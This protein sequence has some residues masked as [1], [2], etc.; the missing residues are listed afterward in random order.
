MENRIVVPMPLCIMLIGL[1][2]L[3][4][5]IA[6]IGDQLHSLESDSACPAK[7]DSVIRTNCNVDNCQSVL[8]MPRLHSYKLRRRFLH[9]SGS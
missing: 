5:P 6:L 8:T 4:L 7:H 3:L 2:S 9:S 1:A